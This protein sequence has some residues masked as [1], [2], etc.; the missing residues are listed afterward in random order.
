MPEDT[1]E[2]LKRKECQDCFVHQIAAISQTEQLALSQIIAKKE[3]M[4][5]ALA[6]ELEAL[7]QR[8]S[9]LLCRLG[10]QNGRTDEITHWIPIVGPEEE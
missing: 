3:E 5:A 9:V 7:H 1:P 8:H 10:E 2:Y 6:D 4:I